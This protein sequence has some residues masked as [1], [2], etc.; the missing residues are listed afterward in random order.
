MQTALGFGT[1]VVAIVGLGFVA[2][3]LNA[4]R[5][6][7]RADFGNLYI[8]RYWKIDDALL[9]EEKGT[10]AHNRHRHRYVRLSRIN[11]TSRPSG[12]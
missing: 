11:S 5:R 9:I 7:M 12:F 2:G 1:L 4:Q 6:A 10:E 3:Q 8:Q